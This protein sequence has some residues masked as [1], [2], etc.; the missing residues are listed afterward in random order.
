MTSNHVNVARGFYEFLKSV[1]GDG[2]DRGEDFYKK[3]ARAFTVNDVSCVLSLREYGACVCVQAVDA[4]D[5]IGFDVGMCPKES[6]PS[7]GA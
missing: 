1:D 7:G 6:I 5:L 2:R 4:S 3:V